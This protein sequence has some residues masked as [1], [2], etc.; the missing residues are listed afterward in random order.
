MTGEPI[1]ALGGGSAATVGRYTYVGPTHTWRWSDGIY[2]IHGYDPGEVE[3]T[4]ELLIAHKHPDD[5]SSAIEVF[6]KV[7]QTGEPFS[8]YHR[9]IDKQ[10]QIRH[11]VVSGDG[12][13]NDVGVVT[14]L[15]GYLVDL[16]ESRRRDTAG[17]DGAAV[18]PVT[19]HRVVIEQ[20]KGALMLTY[21]LDAD[22][23]LAVLAWRSHNANIK[24][25]ELADRLV[26]AITHGATVTAEARHRMDAILDDLGDGP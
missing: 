18:A 14:L 16:T 24:L 1:E 11:V 12:V 17:G 9:I 20:A 19:A 23:A 25:H 22:A 15:R 3:P 6:E 7:Q 10:G 4:T 21:G 26:H 5:R 8:F 13:I 2:L